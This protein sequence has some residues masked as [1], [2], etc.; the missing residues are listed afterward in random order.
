MLHQPPPVPPIAIG[1]QLMRTLP[2][3]ADN[4]LIG[5]PESRAVYRTVPANGM[6]TSTVYVNNDRLGSGSGKSKKVAERAAAADA[7][8]NPLVKKWQKEMI[9]E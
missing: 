4:V 9:I 7:L 3:R 8:N 1:L 5:F 6:F 2:L